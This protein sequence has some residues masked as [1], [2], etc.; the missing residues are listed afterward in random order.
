MKN[1]KSKIAVVV[2][3]LMLTLVVTANVTPTTQKIGTV[4]TFSLGHDYW[5]NY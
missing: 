1:L 2:S 5:V 3:L 4:S